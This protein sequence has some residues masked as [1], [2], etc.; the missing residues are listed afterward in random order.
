MTTEALWL[1][2]IAPLGLALLGVVPAA[3]ANANAAG[4]AL[5]AR[6]AAFLNFTAA[7]LMAGL[8]GLMGPMHTPA[9]P[10]F[11]LWFDSLTAVIDRKSTRLNSSHRNTSR[12]PSSA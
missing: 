12:M 10:G 5:W 3:I 4:M 1:L 9:V 7:V 11:G 2:L 8:L 6:I